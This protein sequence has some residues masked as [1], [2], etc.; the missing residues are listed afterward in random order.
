MKNVNSR[1]HK[2]HNPA[3]FG[4]TIGIALG[5]SIG[6][7]VGNLLLGVGIGMAVGALF[8]IGLKKK[9]DKSNSN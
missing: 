5:C 1:E 3:A 9:R 6:I 8:G 7:L 2:I 4:L